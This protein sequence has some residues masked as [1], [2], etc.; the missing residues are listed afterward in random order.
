M[1]SQQCSEFSSAKSIAF[2]VPALPLT[3]SMTL[4]TYFAFFVQVAFINHH[5]SL[6][7]LLMVYPGGAL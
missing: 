3:L 1:F 7:L 2:P 4:Q 6:A 5:D